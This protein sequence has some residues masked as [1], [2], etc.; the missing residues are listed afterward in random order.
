MFIIILVLVSA[1]WHSDSPVDLREIYNSFYD[2]T[3]LLFIRRDTRVLFIS[4]YAD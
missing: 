4:E 1:N 3:N 2:S